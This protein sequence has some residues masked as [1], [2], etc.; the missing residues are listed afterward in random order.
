MNAIYLFKHGRRVRLMKGGPLEFLY[1]QNN[2]LEFGI[3]SKI[4]EDIDYSLDR[5]PN[6]LVRVID[7]CFFYS[8]GAMI[9]TPLRIIWSGLLGRLNQSKVVVVPVLSYG[10]ALAILKRLGLLK[11][12]ILL[13]AM[14]M[15][16]SK[17]PRR[18]LFFYKWAFKY[19]HVVCLSEKDAKHTALYL[20]R[21]IGHITF[22]VDTKFWTPKSSAKMSSTPY[23]LSIGNDPKRDYETL[24]NAWTLEM[25]LLHII[26][27]RKIKSSQSNIKIS[28][29]DWRSGGFSDEQIREFMRN[30]LFVVVPV[31]DCI[32]PSGQS[33]GLQAMSC[34][35][36]IIVTD[37]PG[38]WDRKILIDGETCLYGGLPGDHIRLNATIL[39]ILHNSALRSKIEINAR[40]AV[41]EGSNI[42][43]MTNAVSRE[44][45]RCGEY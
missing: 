6:I 16:E 43:V 11:A 22:G 10:V 30:A 41:Q 40:R 36:A 8:I 27:N 19:V 25:P 35:K 9:S 29:G 12:N 14:G 44:I 3:N 17:T 20:N 2:V 39:N 26:T 42:M 32:Q 13:F 5:R 34:G 21:H 4:I 33:A 37:Y 38:L 45:F 28:T 18:I 24:L 23:V 15:F 7:L 1:G 31:S